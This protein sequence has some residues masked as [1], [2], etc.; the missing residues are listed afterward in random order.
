[1]RAP[2]SVGSPQLVMRGISGRMDTIAHFRI[3]MQLEDA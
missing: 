3:E 2:Q 1:M